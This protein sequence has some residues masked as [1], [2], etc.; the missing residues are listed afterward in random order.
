MEPRNQVHRQEAT[1]RDA[2]AVRMAE[3]NIGCIGSARGIQARVVGDPE[4]VRK[5]LDWEPGD[6]VSVCG[7]D[8]L[9]REV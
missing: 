6:P 3:S 2:D 9:H 8:R 1:L 7:V 5:H 4:H